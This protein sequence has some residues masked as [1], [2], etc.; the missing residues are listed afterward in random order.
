M[1]TTSET[2]TKIKKL[3]QVGVL[4]A[5][6]FLLDG[7][8]IYSEFEEIMSLST[9]AKVRNVLEEIGFIKT[10]SPEG[11]KLYHSLT[12]EGERAAKLLLKILDEIS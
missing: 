12:P 10:R 3:E 2:I 4:R 1:N 8:R 5:L 11:K 9:F 7:E 6:P